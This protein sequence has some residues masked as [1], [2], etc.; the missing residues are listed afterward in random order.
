[1]YWISNGTGGWVIFPMPHACTST[2]WTAATLRSDTD[3]D[4]CAVNTEDEM[5]SWVLSHQLALYAYWQ[6]LRFFFLHCTVTD[7]CNY[8]GPHTV[9]E[10]EWI[11]LRRWKCEEASGCLFSSL[12]K[13]MT[14]AFYLSVV[15]ASSWALT[16]IELWEVGIPIPQYLVPAGIY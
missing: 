7:T 8:A 11:I 3:H 4:S 14:A 6:P 10:V 2:Y 12:S 5:E 13:V 16:I 1:M 15:K 9:T